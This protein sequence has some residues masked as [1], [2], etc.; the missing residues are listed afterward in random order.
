M[1]ELIIRFHD[2]ALDAFDW[3]VYQDSEVLPALQ[4][5]SGSESDLGELI[6]SQD[7][8][9]VLAIP[10]H[11]AL[12]THFDLPAKASRQILSSIEFQIEDQ[13]ADDIDR[14]HFA[15]GN[16]ENNSVP[17]VVIKK[18]IMQRCQALQKKFN[19]TISTIIPELFLCPWSGQAGDISVLES[20]DGVI[21]RFGHYQGFKCQSVLLKSMLDQLNRKYPIKRVN[22]FYTENDV[23]E[24]I[25]VEGYESQ[26]ANPTINHLNNLKTTNFDLR[27]RE[28]KRSSI[29]GG[30]VKFWKW[31]AVIFVTFL[32]IFSYNKLVH[33]D[34]LEDQLADI[35]FS[36]YV[37]VK[38]Y[39]PLGTSKSDN[40]KKK[41][42]ELIKLSK[43]NVSDKDFLSQL[44]I[45]T[46]AK[47]KYSSVIITQINFQKLRLS[48]DINSTKL[49]D[50]EALVKTL[51]LSALTV[52]LENLTIK[53]EFISGRLV[54]GN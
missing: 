8:S 19:M 34:E 14:Q 15:I 21:L 40:L 54:L 51:E 9:V 38:A 50:V 4:W 53:P 32:I 22:Y 3:L 17:I 28:F 39:L 25:K 49:N 1:P 11:C 30:I 43:A 47:Q 48:I 33:L 31:V 46:K 24:E 23:Y 26:K 5:C 29:W 35:R 20:Q 16:I 12:M 52:K 41:L 44:V 36:Q 2:E 7:T 27:Q 10:Q 18:L 45:F 42:I 6:S 13:L 37:A